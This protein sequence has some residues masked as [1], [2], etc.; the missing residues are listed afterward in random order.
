MQDTLQHTLQHFT[1]RI[2][3][4][5]RTGQPL[6]LR[7]G[8][9][10][11][12]LGQSLN[13][14]VLDVTAYSGILSY[15]PSELV[16]TV[17]GGTSLSEVES[18][19]AEKGQCFAFDPP[20][21]GAGATIGGMV[22]AGLSGPA[23]ASVG[24]VRDFVLGA[25]VINGKGEHL[26][27][28]GQVMKNVAG[29]DVSRLL[30]G[31]WGQLGLITEVSLKVLPV[32]PGEA[33]LVCAGVSQEQ[34][35]TLLNR[36][37]GQPLPLNASAWVHDTTASPAQDYLFVRLRGA[38]AAVEAAVAKMAA[39]VQALGA[40]VTRMDHTAA[41]AD[42][43]ASGEQTLDF[44]TPPSEQACLWRLSVPQ[45][46]PVLQLR[47]QGQSCAQYLEW[48]GAQRWVW[49]PASEVAHIREAAASVGGHATLFRTSTA[50]RQTHGDVDKQAGV[51]TPLNAVQ[52]R[53]QDE[54]KKQFDPAGIFNPGRA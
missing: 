33:T 29:Y 26:T 31:S 17:R 50:S 40:Q 20:H 53:I 42:W 27:F 48:H 37:G 5:S 12:F 18:A 23:R 39:E 34:A 10:K 30:A 9:T 11:D 35:L 46:A 13:G 44:F 49:A 32:A 52:Q 21:F 43:K 45:T 8:G 22:A 28:G 19:L 16:I 6:R 41:A 47:V 3:Q 51:Y 1:D 25:R 14:E 7:G 38:V 54:L 2:L 4:A 15:E 24:T 36:W